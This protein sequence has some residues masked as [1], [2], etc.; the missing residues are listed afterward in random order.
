MGKVLRGVV[1]IGILGSI[2]FLIVFFLS[3]KQVISPVP[4]EGAIRIIYISPS[5]TGTLSPSPTS[6]P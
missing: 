1:L 5:P 2:V 4:E 6:K 3:Q